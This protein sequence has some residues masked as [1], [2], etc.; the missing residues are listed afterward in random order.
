MPAIRSAGLVAV[1]ALC[2]L[3]AQQGGL[4][5]IEAIQDPETRSRK[6]LTFAWSQLD[7]A[8]RAYRRDDP[9]AGRRALEAIGQA[10]ALS[11]AS[12]EATGKYARR[13]PKHF[14]H[15]EIQTRKLLAQLKTS[16][17]KALLAD[18]ADFVGPIEQVEAANAELLLGLMGPRE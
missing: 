3:A 14:K 16:Q 6:A 13:H 7:V 8:T 17:G 2:C 12:L 11:A 1:A 18:Q 5:P 9:E 10:A 15:A 4:A